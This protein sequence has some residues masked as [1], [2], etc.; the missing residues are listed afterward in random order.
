MFTVLLAMAEL[1]SNWVRGKFV[2]LDTKTGRGFFMIFIGLMIPQNNNGVSVAMSVITNLIGLI[3]LFV[4]YGQGSDMK[5]SSSINWQP[6]E[7]PIF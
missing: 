1:R 6:S 2:F 7:T 4:G 3:N 5:I